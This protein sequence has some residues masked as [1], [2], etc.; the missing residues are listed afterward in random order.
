MAWFPGGYE[1]TEQDL[2]RL[3]ELGVHRA[4]CNRPDKL[5]S[6]QNKSK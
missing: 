4:C 2:V 5:Q 6:I 1:E 3:I